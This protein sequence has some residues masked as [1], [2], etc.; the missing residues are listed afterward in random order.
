MIISTIRMTTFNKKRNEASKIFNMT[1]EFC[2]ILQECLDCD[3]HEDLQDD[4]I[5]MLRQGWRRKE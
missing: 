4:S 5:L 1:A 2:R 3:I